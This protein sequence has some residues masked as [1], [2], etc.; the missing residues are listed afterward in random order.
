MVALLKNVP[1]ELTERVRQLIQDQAGAEAYLVGGAVR[2]VLLG[3]ATKDYDLVVRGVAADTLEAWLAQHGQV[4]LVGKT[5]GIFKWQPEGWGGEAI[6]VAL[7]RTEHAISG[8]GQYRD[9]AIQSEPNLPIESDLA[10]RDFTVNALALDLLSGKIIDPNEGQA[11]LKRK[12]L[13]TVGEPALRFSEDL[14]RTLRGVRFACQLGFEIEKQTWTAIQAQAERTSA[15]TAADGTWLVPREIIARE[16]LKAL[17]ANPPRALEL[18]DE[19]TFLSKLLPEVTA[20]KGCPQPPEFHSE[21]DV[22]EHTKLALGALTSPAWKEFFGEA[23]PSLNVIVA[24]LLH[25]I[26]KPLTLKTPEVHGTN[27]IRTDG[28]DVA[29][30]E[31]VPQICERLKLTSYVDPTAGQIDVEAVSWFVQ[32]HLIL[33]HGR[34]EN[35]KPSTIYRYFLVNRVR[36][37]ELQQLIFADSY[38]S[39]PPQGKP[40]AQLL[41]QLRARLPEVEAK[42]TSGKLTLLLS[43][44]DL[45]K[46]LK[47][48]PGPKIGE[49]LRALEEAQLES[50]VKSKD[51]ALALLKTLL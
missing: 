41:E 45:M 27:R 49:L 6:D 34:P 22:F 33:V 7:P 2:D 9:F 23:K 1:H 26:G 14:S 18:W 40:G 16:L 20:M 39:R 21:G 5:F 17:I 37:L 12:I 13:R 4:V 24:T 51:E 46:N 10:R 43:G 50:K 29:G 15:G 19:S 28:H 44:N 42:L 38:A 11:D 8:T 25:D 47:L 32:H 36:G 30:A 35:L 31:L 48:T 3:R